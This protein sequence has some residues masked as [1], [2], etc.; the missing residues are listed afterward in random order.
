[1]FCKNISLFVNSDKKLIEIGCR[2]NC[3][4]VVISEHCAFKHRL[5][6]SL[7]LATMIEAVA[8]T[9]NFQGEG[10]VLSQSCD[11]TNQL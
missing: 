1:M 5:S 8:Y 10:K 3:C 7:P 2:P 6:I 11:V 9:E 4:T